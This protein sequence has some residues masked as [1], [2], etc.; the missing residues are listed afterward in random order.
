VRHL[1]VDAVV[2]AVPA[3]QAAGLLAGHAPLASS[4]LGDVE[5]SS[6]TVVT[7]SMAAGSVRSP[8]VGTGFLVPRTS[9]IG[10]RPA[11]I[12]GC[13]YLSRKWPGLARTEDELIRLSV[14][15]HGDTRPDSLDDDELT[16]AAVAELGAVLDVAGRP[17]ASMV[18][19]WDGA[20]PQYRVGHLAR[21]A[22]IELAV[23]ALPGVA[24]AGATYRGVGIP[25]VIGSG[26]TAART[27]LRSLD[28]AAPAR[29]GR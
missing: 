12:T 1:D 11:L 16:A 3:G 24:V 2:L 10:G 9:T 25:A 23:A 13:T 15:R 8:L 14:G 28:G 20:F 19:R 27:V 21:T 29:P 4:L 6:V 18:T 7:L 5:H 22:T 17:R 26:R